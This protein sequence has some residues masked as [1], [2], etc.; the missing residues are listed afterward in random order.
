MSSGLAQMYRDMVVAKAIQG[1]EKQEIVV[2]KSSW[3]HGMCLPC[4]E[5]MYLRKRIPSA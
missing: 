2:D 4:S 1:G 3:T 5:R